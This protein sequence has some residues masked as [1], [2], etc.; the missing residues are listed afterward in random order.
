MWE[1]GRQEK[2]QMGL[3]SFAQ[4]MKA[5]HG[6]SAEETGSAKAKLMELGLV[7][8]GRVLGRGFLKL[9]KKGRAVAQAE[10]RGRS[11]NLINSVFKK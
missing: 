5:R 7:E 2:Q 4:I 1:I 10:E 6:K 8:E 9:T 3:D 11:K